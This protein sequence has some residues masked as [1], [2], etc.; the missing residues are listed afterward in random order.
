MTY[1]EAKG[2]TG[3]W[4]ELE[5]R[6]WRCSAGLSHERIPFEESVDECEELLLLLGRQLLD[7][8]QS[9]QKPLI[10]RSDGDGLRR[11]ESE[12]LVRGNA[13]EVDERPQQ[14]R[15]RMLGLRL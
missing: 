5:C 3:M 12:E 9:L 10:R 15:W 14:V 11:P 8:P 1:M 13:E 6:G 2:L 4:S 7:A